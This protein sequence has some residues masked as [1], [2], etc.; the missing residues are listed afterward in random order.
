MVTKKQKSK[1]SQQSDG[2]AGDMAKSWYN[3]NLDFSISK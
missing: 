3:L 2:K 1:I